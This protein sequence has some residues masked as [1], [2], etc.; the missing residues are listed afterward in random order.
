MYALGRL[1]W[2]ELAV[3]ESYGVAE[4][5]YQLHRQ[6]HGPR[7]TSDSGNDHHSLCRSTTSTFTATASGGNL[8]SYGE[9]DEYPARG[10]HDLVVVI[11]KRH[12]AYGVWWL[13]GKSGTFGKPKRRPL[14]DHHLHNQ[15][16]RA[17]R[18]RAV[19]RDGDSHGAGVSD[20]DRLLA[21]GRD[22]RSQSESGSQS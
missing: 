11:G 21:E 2:R 17:G 3:R 18:S 8:S 9:S 4:P 22:D 14:G 10:Y 7:G 13:V 12:V 15:L 16:Q 20:V 19:E 1:E 5:D 6:L